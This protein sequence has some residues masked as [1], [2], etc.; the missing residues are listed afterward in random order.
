[1][2]VPGLCV[3]CLSLGHG[4][5]GISEGGGNFRSCAQMEEA[6]LKSPHSL[7]VAGMKHSDQKQ[8][9]GGRGVVQLPDHSSS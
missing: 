1:M 6:I 9:R 3:G 8:H 7:P 2:S 5:G 4:G